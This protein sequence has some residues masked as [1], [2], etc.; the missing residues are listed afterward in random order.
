MNKREVECTEVIDML[1]EWDT[2]TF[3]TDDIEAIEIVD[4]NWHVITNTSE[5]DEENGSTYKLR[6]TLAMTFKNNCVI[7]R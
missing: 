7:F 2:V 4:D 6:G 5:F 3:N 1:M